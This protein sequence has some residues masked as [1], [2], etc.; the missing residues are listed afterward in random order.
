MAKKLIKKNINSSENYALYLVGD[1]IF[2]LLREFYKSQY[3][4]DSPEWKS[5][6]DND[7]KIQIEKKRKK[8]NAD[9]RYR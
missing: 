2:D 9:R 7:K 4:L 6:V 5:I 1:P 3:G 8:I